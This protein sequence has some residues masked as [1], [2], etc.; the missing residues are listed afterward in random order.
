MAGV[1]R[2]QLAAD[3]DPVILREGRLF[4]NVLCGGLLALLILALVRGLAGAN[5]T[6]GR[7]TVAVIFGALIALVAWAWVMMIRLRGH[8][9]ITAQAITYAGYA[10]RKPQTLTLSRQQGDV[11][12]VVQRGAPR[13]PVRC[14]TAQG[15]STV[16]PVSLFRLSQVRQA[17]A[18]RGWQFQQGQDPAG[19]L[20]GWLLSSSSR[21]AS[22]NCGAHIRPLCAICVSA[23]IDFGRDWLAPPILGDRARMSN[24]APGTRNDSPA[25]Q[26]CQSITRARISTLPG[27][28]PPPLNSGEAALLIS[29]KSLD[30]VSREPFRRNAVRQL[31]AS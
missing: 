29:T 21:L 30:F 27:P 13:Y 20:P 19:P 25:L 5:T 22:R 12:R 17:C 1:P 11:L 3:A 26:H 23:Q 6:A 15:S 7:M 10:R 31:A 28:W 9:E 4:P 16:I 18:A 24:R 2:D 8:L 14:L